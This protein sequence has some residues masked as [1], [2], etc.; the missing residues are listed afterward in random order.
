MGRYQIKN[1]GTVP[2][3]SKQ[4]LV[5]CSTSQ[6]NQGCNGG[7]MDYGFTY[8][9]NTG[10]ETESQYPYT[11]RDGTCQSVS[12][13]VTVKNFADVQANSPSQLKAAVAQGPVSIALDGAGLAFQFYFGGIIKSLCGT[14]LDHGVLI[15]GYG[16]ENG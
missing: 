15:V 9:E 6:G 7:L 10:L 14:S 8:A 5:D 12:G 3:L 16:S 2:S 4:Q 11:G 1:G 13:G